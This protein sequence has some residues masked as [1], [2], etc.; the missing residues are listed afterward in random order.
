MKYLV[1]PKADDPRTRPEA[2]REKT[3]VWRHKRW[4]WPSDT[5]LG[6]HFRSE[7]LARSQQ[8]LV[9]RHLAQF[10]KPVR[11][12]RANRLIAVDNLEIG[13]QPVQP[14]ERMKLVGG[15]TYRTSAGHPGS[16]RSRPGFDLLS[17]S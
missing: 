11:E 6:D 1:L 4:D 5:C 16:G 7:S 10:F 14:E 12:R 15:T 17:Q 3:Y 8:D 9:P 2:T 13:L